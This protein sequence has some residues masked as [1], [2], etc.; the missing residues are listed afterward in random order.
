M[1]ESATFNASGDII[2]VIDGVAMTVPDDMANR[3]RRKVAAW[4]AA[5]GVIAAYVA[6]APSPEAVRKANLEALP[7]TVDMIA[8]LRNATPAQIRTWL[9]NN[10]TT[11]TNSREVMAIVLIYLA[12]KL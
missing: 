2:A 7:E 8:K 9:G 10:W 12:S 1:I 11:I 5:G 6:P 4:E 3:D